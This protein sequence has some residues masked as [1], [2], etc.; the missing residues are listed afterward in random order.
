[1]EKT[2]LLEKKEILGYMKDVINDLI[3]S[4]TDITDYRFHHSTNYNNAVNVC[5]YGIINIK[6]QN[7]LGLR[8]DS[9]EYLEMMD[10]E[11][12]HVNG[13]EN[14]SL[15]VMG[16][17]DLY[18]GEEEYNS[19]NPYLVD[20]LLSKDIVARRKAL[21]YGNEFLCNGV[22][23]DK[24]KSVDIRL[25]QFLHKVELKTDDQELNKIINN[26][27]SLIDIAN[28]MYIQKLEIP[29]REMSESNIY[30]LDVDRLLEQPKLNIKTS[31]SL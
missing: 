5:K 9:K 28:E 1:M 29:L 27:N 17:T 15:A 10:D 30:D 18:K 31:N 14:V 20:F 24:I 6:E 7:R 25:L 22:S 11:Y 16:L 19:Y 4:G 23:V 21:H 3:V 2:I 13:I 8:N 26:F 12:S